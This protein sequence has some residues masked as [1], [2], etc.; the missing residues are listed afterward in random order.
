MWVQ[1]IAVGWLTWELTSGLDPAQRVEIRALLQSLAASDRTVILST[2]VLS[3]IEAVCQRAI[4]IDRGRLVAQD[5]IA[6]LRRA[7]GSVELQLARPEGAEAAL[8]AWGTV[9]DL[10]DGH[11]RVRTPADNREQ[12]AA[13]AVPFG[14]L[15]LSSRAALEDVYLRLTSD[16][17]TA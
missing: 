1:R 6:G 4:I 3:E 16:E 17:A 12:L 9:L 10:G 13:A 15:E 7:T 11:F 14:L 2:H 5:T 8:A